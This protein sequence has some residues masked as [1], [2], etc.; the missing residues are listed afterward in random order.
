MQ[1]REPK[2]KRIE[3]HKFLA[4]TL[5][6]GDFISVGEHLIMLKRIKGSSEAM[7]ITSAPQSVLVRLHKR[8]KIDGKGA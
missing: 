7:L 1:N 4:L 8:D 2:L 5:R 6:V 3:G